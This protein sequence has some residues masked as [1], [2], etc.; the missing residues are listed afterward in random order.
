MIEDCRGADFRIETDRLVIRGWKPDDG[1]PFAELNADPRVMTYFPRC[2]KAEETL[3]MIGKLREKIAADGFTFM[4]VEEKG[5]G[6]FVG[7][8]GLN[9]PVFPQPVSI[10]PC[11][12]IGWRLTPATWGRGY[13]TEAAR[14][15]LRFGFE[16]LRLDEIVA[17]TV[18]TNECS[19]AVMRCLGMTERGHFDHPSVPEDRSDLK[20]HVLYRM[21]SVDWKGASNGKGKGADGDRQDPM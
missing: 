13:A 4:P 8:V 20:V 11:V 1:K 19:R 16:T 5:S 7:I 3:A 17:F 21:K 6:R 12:E 10:A 15:W 14:A 2:L 9:R 18:V